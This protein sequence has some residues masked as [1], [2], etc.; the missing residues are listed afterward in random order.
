MSILFRLSLFV[1]SYYSA[2]SY[3]ENSST[4]TPA[5]VAL[6][7]SE[8][9]LQEEVHTTPALSLRCSDLLALTSYPIIPETTERLWRF[10]GH[11]T[12]LATFRW[13]ET[14]EEKGAPSPY[15]PCPSL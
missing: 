4:F 1:L 2:V 3:V 11:T 6:H 8:V 5:L 10:L 13:D 9:S 15:R 7:L 12:P 14:V